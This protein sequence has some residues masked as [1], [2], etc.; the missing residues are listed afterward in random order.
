[1]APTDRG[2]GEPFVTQ[3]GDEQ[4]GLDAQKK[5]VKASERDEAA[6]QVWRESM[7]LVAAARLVFVDEC[8][9]HTSLTPLYAYAPRDERAV[10]SVPKNR[11]ENTTILGALNAEGL[12]A[13]MTVEGAADGA[14]FEAFVEQVLCPTLQPGQIVIMDNLSTHK[15]ARIR[16]LIEER[17]CRLWFLPTYSPDLNPIEMAWSKLKAY[18]RVVSARTRDALQE[19][20][21]QG[22]QTITA[23]D[24]R[25]WLK[26]CYQLIW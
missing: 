11:G 18:L 6:R 9:S 3:A 15:S 2:H 12:Q 14:V 10:G 26:H 8:G 5:S 24:A 25:N 23:Q 17:H 19:A 22:L 13:A 7:A 4:T 16:E 1:M 20:I 21:G